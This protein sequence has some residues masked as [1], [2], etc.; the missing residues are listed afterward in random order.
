MTLMISEASPAAP[1]V[2][3]PPLLIATFSAALELGGTSL[4]ELLRYDRVAV[5]D[6]QWWRL[7]SSNF[8]HLGW[9]HWFLNALSLVLLVFLCPERIKPLSWLLRLAVIGIG[10]CFCL[11]VFTPGLANYVGLSGLV[12][13][14]FALG[15]GRQIA[16]GERFAIACLVFLAARIVW[17]LIIGAPASEEGL[18]GGS[19]VAESHLYGVLA[20]AVYGL[21]AGSFRRPVT[22]TA[23]T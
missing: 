20:A 13:G 11:H 14:L 15:F 1:A 12:Y 9:W 5:V 4:T 16:S 18:I 17:E 10:M 23:G 22:V 2:W 8:V 6:G 19:V 7:L 21:C 3:L